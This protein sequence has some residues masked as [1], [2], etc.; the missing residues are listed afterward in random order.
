MGQLI[1]EQMLSPKGKARGGRVWE[2]PGNGRKPVQLEDTK[3]RE[4]AESG[5]MEVVMG[6]GNGGC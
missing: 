5:E 3:G 6:G 4:E 1:M 2:L